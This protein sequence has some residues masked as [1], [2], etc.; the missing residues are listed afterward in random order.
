MDE[1][2]ILLFC[3]HP[4]GT[5]MAKQP[6]KKNKKEQKI[7]EIK[8][9]PSVTDVAD[10]DLMRLLCPEDVVKI[11]K[12]FDVKI[13]IKNERFYI[14]SDNIRN[15]R[16]AANVLEKLFDWFDSD[17][18][19]EAEAVDDLIDEYLPKTYSETKYKNIFTTVDGREISPRT[20]NQERVVKTIKNKKISIIGGCAGGGKT[21]FALTLG[22]KFLFDGRF[23]QLVITRPISTVG[24]SLG[25]MP[26]DVDEKI[27]L[28]Y[29]TIYAE[30]FNLVGDKVLAQMIAEKK[31]V[32]T[33]VSFLRGATMDDSYIVID[34]VQNLTEHEL[35][36][37][38]TRLGMNSKI[39]LTGDSSQ[40]DIKNV[41]DTA[42]DIAIEKLSD[43]EDVGVVKM[44]EHDIQRSKLV[45]D[46]VRMFD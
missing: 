18:F 15:C 42:L 30:L 24:N 38:L 14:T 4:K 27:Q 46:I 23:N 26:G 34:E 43:F 28:Y 10:I 6:I 19:V 22:L 11:K 40:V 8:I 9:T 44:T 16:K 32:F 31:I 29:E 20:I 13:D 1:Y 37:I 25:Y 36:T 35:K 21:L 45:A 7:D 3:F 41:K 12:S 17:V 5:T 33:P 39:V 2:P